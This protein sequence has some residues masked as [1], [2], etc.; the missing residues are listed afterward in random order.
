MRQVQSKQL[1]IGEVDIGSIKLDHRSRDDIP[2]I[3]LGLQHL[4]LNDA[5]R[6]LIFS[7]LEQAIPENISRTKGRPGMHLWKILVLGVLRLNLDWNYDRLREMANQHA[8]IR[9]MLGHGAYDSFEYK[10]QTLKDNVSLLTPELLNHINEVAV[11]E[12]HKI[13]GKK[14]GFVESPLRLL[15]S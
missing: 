1:Q 14:R 5:A 13:V 6:D 8:T 10:L 15:C 12:G 7:I 9:E 4:Y 3:L 11:V 2:Q